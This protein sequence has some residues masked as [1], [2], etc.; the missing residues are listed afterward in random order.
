VG[1]NIAESRTAKWS[2]AITLTYGRNRVGDADHE[3]AVILT[4]SDVQ[5]WIKL[6]RFHGFP[7]RYFVT[8]EFGSLKG[9]AH[10]HVMLY[11]SGPMPEHK[12]D[13]SH[14]LGGHWAHGWSFWTEPSPQAV[15]YNCKYVQKDIGEAERQGHLAMSKK[16]P[17][18][19]TYFEWLADAYAEQGLAPRDLFYSFPDVLTKDGPEDVGKPKEFMLNNRSA[20]LFLERFV[21]K[22]AERQPGRP[23]PNS[24]LV[25]NWIEYGVL[26]VPPVE[27]GVARYREFMERARER[28]D[29]SGPHNVRP[30]RF[31]GSESAAERRHRFNRLQEE[32]ESY[33]EGQFQERFGSVAERIEKF[34]RERERER[35]E[36]VRRRGERLKTKGGRKKRRG[37][38]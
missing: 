29:K 10:W 20:G 3:R 24:E 14:F 5:K 12:L 26:R 9:R 4:Y 27:D 21:E 31:S 30:S 22:W 13:D 33:G 18:G 17:L 11:G 32:S 8:G 6:L 19:A 16:P 34:E 2:R 36:Y 25:S 1:R 35:Q 38:F 7:V 15:R 23:L 37:G 28:R